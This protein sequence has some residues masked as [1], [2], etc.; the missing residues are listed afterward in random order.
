MT[1][2]HDV[3]DSPPCP[4]C[5]GETCPADEAPGGAAVFTLAAALRYCYSCGATFLPRR[6]VIAGPAGHWWAYSESFGVL[7]CKPMSRGERDH[8]PPP[9]PDT[10]AGDEWA[11]HEWGESEV[12]PPATVRALLLLLGRDPTERVEVTR[13]D[14]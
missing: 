8:E 10:F 4:R 7:F 11:D 2:V 1:K 14:D 9:H 6:A 3:L 12:A 5:S 13:L